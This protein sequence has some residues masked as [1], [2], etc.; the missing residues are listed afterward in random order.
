MD[1][2]GNPGIAYRMRNSRP[3]IKAASQSTAHHALLFFPPGRPDRKRSLKCHWRRN[4][5]RLGIFHR[6]DH[7]RAGATSQ[8]IFEPSLLRRVLRTAHFSARPLH[9][10]DRLLRFSDRRTARINLVWRMSQ[11][12]DRSIDRPGVRVTS[13][14]QCSF[15]D[16]TFDLGMYVIN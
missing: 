12:L 6:L 2:N 1:T 3:A 15:L 13:W 7:V 4:R 5:N 9:Y 10:K 8:T 16:E 11:I 14:P